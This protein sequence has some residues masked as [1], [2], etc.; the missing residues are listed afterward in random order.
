MKILA[1]DTGTAVNTVALCEDGRLLA[2]TVSLCGRAHS[3]RLLATVDWILRETSMQLADLD[4]FAVSI[5]PGSFTGVRV[6][7]AAW[8]GLALAVGKPLYG[9]S[10]M[11]AMSR[12]AGVEHGLVC[13]VL[14]AKMGEVFAAVF[15]WQDGVRTRLTEDRVC[16][17]EALRDAIEGPVRFLGDGIARYRERLEAAFPEALFIEEAFG[18][19]RAISIALEAL[20]L[21]RS[22][23]VGDPGEAAPVY[24]RKSQAELNRDR[25]MAEGRV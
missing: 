17:V 24:L 1:V 8:K 14:D 11:A 22:G 2:E 25:A 16:P 3:E 5:G 6:G 23:A 13:P 15:Q 21:A 10:A 4:A 9:V 20:A 12:L 18:A 7:V 19:P